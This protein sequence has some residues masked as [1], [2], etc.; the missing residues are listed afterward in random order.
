MVVA[1]R[2]SCD[3]KPCEK[4]T[5]RVELVLCRHDEDISWAFDVHRAAVAAHDTHSHK[6]LPPRLTVYNNGAPMPAA[7]HDPHVRF[8]AIP[9]KGREAL[10]YVEHMLRLKRLAKSCG[11]ACAPDF[12]V[13]LQARMTCLADVGV[14]VTDINAKKQVEQSRCVDRAA[15]LLGA[16]DSGR[17]K[18]HPY[19]FVDVNAG[20]TTRYFVERSLC[21][22]SHLR[23]TGVRS[24][25]VPS[26]VKSF[27]PMAQFMVAREN[28]L[29]MPTCWLAEVRAALLRSKEFPWIQP[30]A[31]GW[32][33][34]QAS[35]A[36]EKMC[37][38]R[39]HTCLPWKLERVW[40][41]LLSRRPTLK[42]A[43][44]ARS[45]IP[46]TERDNSAR[47][48]SKRTRQC[49]PVTLGSSDLSLGGF[50][51]SRMDAV[52]QEIFMTILFMTDADARLA[53][54]MSDQRLSWDLLDERLKSTRVPHRFQS[55]FERNRVWGIC[56]PLLRNA[57]LLRAVTPR[58]EYVHPRDERDADIPTAV[59]VSRVPR[60]AELDGPDADT[61]FRF[62]E[63]ANKSAP[64]G[65][66]T[67]DYAHPMN[68]FQ[69]V[70]TP[71]GSRWLTASAAS[72]LLRRERIKTL[73]ELG[74]RAVVQ[75]LFM[76]CA[77]LA[78]HIPLGRS[79]L[80]VARQELSRQTLL[81]T[82][83]PTQRD[84]GRVKPKLVVQ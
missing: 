59:V 32:T 16:L 66:Y 45:T 73:L 75:K 43:A 80:E 64:I 31:R 2:P 40:L 74:L 26:R 34:N 5:P 29:E 51:T 53:R 83:A 68:A 49:P 82:A 11:A 52:E 21:S 1:T 79:I 54:A 76:S 30:P 7:S 6:R 56:A 27:T 38:S 18:L 57:S 28:I 72:E 42:V 63:L 33:G 62:F 13:F 71:V 60:L 37:C 69:R 67:V 9:N 47:T 19:G 24:T 44:S 58:V 17:A 48:G 84:V 36:H 8:V 81:E 46:T 14:L 70:A 4:V 25:W 10:C 15:Q 50:L 78:F 12:T 39:S 23:A 41:H 35:V 77:Q 3:A 22:K 20:S 55:R 65:W 61:R